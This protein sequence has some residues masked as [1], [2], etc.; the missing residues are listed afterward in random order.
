[1][2]TGTQQ[3]ILG[4]MPQESCTYGIDGCGVSL[5]DRLHTVVQGIGI[6][7][8]PDH[9]PQRDDGRFGIELIGS[10]RVDHRVIEAPADTIP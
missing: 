1:V 9:I 2:S 6:E 8:G 7:M 3:E 4:L 5:F 10:L